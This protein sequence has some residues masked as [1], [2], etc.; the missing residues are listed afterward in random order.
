VVIDYLNGLCSDQLVKAVIAHTYFDY[1][2]R[3]M[4]IGEAKRRLLGNLLK[5]ISSCLDPIPGPLETAYDACTRNSTTPDMEALLRVFASTSTSMSTVFVIFDGFD[6]CTD[7]LQNF[8]AHLIGELTN[9]PVKFLITS[10]PH[11]HKI[12]TFE[13]A[14]IPIRAETRDVQN[15]LDQRLAHIKSTDLKS[16]ISQKLTA[17]KH[18]MYISANVCKG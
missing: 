7:D 2:E 11:I 9:F 8:I 12:Q 1:K 6:E 13:P 18:E 14:I 10:R 3:S 15:Y 5:Q 17:K 16:K 4:T